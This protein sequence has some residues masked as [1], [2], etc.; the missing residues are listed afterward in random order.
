MWL[1]MTFPQSLEKPEGEMN[2]TSKSDLISILMAGLHTLSDVPD[3]DVKTCMLI[4]GHTLIQS[5][6]EAPWMP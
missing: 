2:V 5:L 4:A 6:W 1:N 3:G